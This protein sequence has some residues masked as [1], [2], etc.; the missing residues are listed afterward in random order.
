M[1]SGFVCFVTYAHKSPLVCAASVFRGFTLWKIHFL[2]SKVF[3]GF[4]GFALFT[5]FCFTQSVFFFILI[6]S[7]LFQERTRT[8]IFFCNV[9]KI[10]GKAFNKPWETQPSIHPS[11]ILFTFYLLLLSRCWRSARA[12]PWSRGAKAGFHPGRVKEK[13]EIDLKKNKSR[14]CLVIDHERFSL[15]CITSLSNC[16]HLALKI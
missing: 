15:Q 16:L 2:K 3:Q 9:H 10:S 4:Q 11:F 5:M 14:K 12:S 1:I 8:F 13:W 7:V 6:G